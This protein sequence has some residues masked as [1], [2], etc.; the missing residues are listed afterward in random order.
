MKKLPKVHQR[1]EV[2][3]SRLFR[4][5]ELDLEFSNG[6]RV[7]YERLVTSGLGAVIVVPVTEDGHVLLVR[8]Y[9]AGLHA[10]ELG[11]PKGRLEPDET[12]EAGAN[13]ELKE[14][15]GFGARRIR[16]IGGLTLAPGYMTHRTEVMLAEDLY[17]E[18]LPGDE[19][20]DI[21]V[22]RWPLA[23]LAGLTAREDVSEGRTIAALY[24]TRDLLED[25]T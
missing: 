11:L 18:R 6:N 1:R 21:D 3:R 14:E 5:Q 12:P 9:A 23:D 7:R 4:V 22:V 10:Y 24:M 2:T 20:E 25:N 16:H 15:A 13:R 17:E 8:E 19:P